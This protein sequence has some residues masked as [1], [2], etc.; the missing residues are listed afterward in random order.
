MSHL[1]HNCFTLKR[2]TQ[3]LIC[4][5]VFLFIGFPFLKMCEC[6]C[7]CF[8]MWAWECMCCMCVWGTYA[9]ICNGWRLTLSSS[10]PTLSIL[11][12]DSWSLS[13]L[14]AHKFFLAGFAAKSRVF[15]CHCLP[16]NGILLVH[17]YPEFYI[18]S[19][20]PNPTSHACLDGTLRSHS[21]HIFIDL[22]LLFIYYMKGVRA[23]VNIQS[24]R[25]HPGQP[26]TH[27]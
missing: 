3:P 20:D 9:P 24:W 11:F 21:T 13:K 4:W 27:L 7:V 1:W 15:S 2:N 25:T 22:E 10:S 18:D 19:R 6:G 14:L 17:W 26:R 12:C 5:F 23:S 8:Y 16:S